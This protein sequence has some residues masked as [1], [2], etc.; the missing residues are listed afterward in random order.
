MTELNGDFL[1]ELLRS[2]PDP[3]ASL[4]NAF[5]RS[6]SDV[7]DAIETSAIAV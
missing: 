3:N 1:R 7:P 6:K 2:I 4:S 5:F